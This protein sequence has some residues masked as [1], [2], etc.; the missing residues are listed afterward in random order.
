MKGYFMKKFLLFVAAALVFVGS[1]AQALRF[2]NHETGELYENN[3]EVKANIADPIMN[4]LDWYFLVLNTS[5]DNHSIQIVAEIEEVNGSL[6]MCGNGNSFPTCN[7]YANAVTVQYG[8]YNCAPG[9]PI[10]YI[11]VSLAFVDFTDDGPVTNTS[12]NARVKYTIYD[13]AN[14][15]E[16]TSITVVFDYA[17]FEEL[18][19]VNSVVADQKVKVFQRGGNLVCNYNFSTRA[20][21][22]IVVSNI[23]GAR[24]AN[25]ALEGGNG[26]AVINRLPKGVYVY[27]LVENG[28]NVKSH[29]VV[30]R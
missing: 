8:P 19:S 22:S 7:N 6:S 9:N 18:A 25:V 11:H 23:V 15:D 14:P 24:V 13:P 2:S 28:R 27:T 10:E 26:E 4:T 16:K 29:K 1:N 5:E 30:I 3:A 12:N 17:T 21:R 20:N